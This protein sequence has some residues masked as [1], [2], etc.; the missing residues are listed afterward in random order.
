GYTAQRT[1]TGAGF[2]FTYVD[3]KGFYLKAVDG[4]TIAQRTISL[5]G[6]NILSAQNANTSASILRNQNLVDGRTTAPPFAY[7]TSPVSF[8]TPLRPTLTVLEPIDIAAI[9]TGQPVA[10]P[11]ADQLNGLIDAL[12]AKAPDGAQQLQVTVSYSV[13]PNPALDPVFLPVLFLPPTS[14]L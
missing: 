13:A 10:R 8:A 1:D 4:Q 6:L 2:T 7:Q 12:F 3:G 11:L 9:P 5:P 14:F